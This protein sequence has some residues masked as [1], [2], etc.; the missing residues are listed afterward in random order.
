MQAA[1]VKLLE[2]LCGPGD[3]LSGQLRAAVVRET[4]KATATCGA[5]RKI[6]VER[7]NVDKNDLWNV[8]AAAKCTFHEAEDCHGLGVVVHALCNL[9]NLMSEAWYKEAAEHLYR[10]LSASE[11]IPDTPADRLLRLAELI[12]V[13]GLAVGFRAFYRAVDAEGSG[14]LQEPSLPATREGKARFGSAA[15]V[16]KHV[17]PREGS[18]W[19]AGFV[20][21]DVNQGLMVGNGEKFFEEFSKLKFMAFSPMNKW[22]PALSTGS[23]FLRWCSVLYSPI[24][25]G[26]ETYHF[27]FKKAP[28]R[29]LNRVGL[30]DAAAGYTT[31]VGCS[32]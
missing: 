5:C 30:E 12:A 25:H 24:Q 14:L 15:E 9:Q 2:E 8:V 21:E 32:F 22:A 26:Y 6:Q 3:F 16:C 23:L 19:G 31:A 13:V 7:K 1:N 17:G 4:L 11:H 29:A 27:M 10:C 18:G 28:G 20:R